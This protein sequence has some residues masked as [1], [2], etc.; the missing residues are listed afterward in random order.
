MLKFWWPHLLNTSWIQSPPLQATATRCIY[1]CPLL[2]LS[3]QPYGWFPVLITISSPISSQVMTLLWSKSPNNFYH[4]GRQ[5]WGL[6]YAL[7]YPTMIL[8][9]LP[10]LP[11]FWSRPPYSIPVTLVFSPIV[12]NVKLISNSGFSLFLLFLPGNLFILI[13][14]WLPLT[15]IQVSLLIF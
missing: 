7:K 2:G 6:Y 14:S 13:V 3:H 4:T 11:H 1:W 10:F 8:S 15:F 5:F 12:E 9:C